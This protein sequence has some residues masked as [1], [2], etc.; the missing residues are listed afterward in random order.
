[1]TSSPAQMREDE[2]RL[3]SVER[4]VEELLAIVGHDARVIKQDNDAQL[5]C[6]LHQLEHSGVGCVEFLGMRV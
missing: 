5:P 2:F 1:M 4:Q 6:P 3:W